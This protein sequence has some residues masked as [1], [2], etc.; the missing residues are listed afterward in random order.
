MAFR[1]NR[2][3]F[4]FL[5]VASSRY[6]NK[7]KIDSDS[8]DLV[9]VHPDTGDALT[10][11][12][13]IGEKASDA[14]TLD[15]I[16]STGFVKTTNN[17]SLNGDTRNTRGVTRLYRREDNSDYSL[18]HYWTGSYWYLKGYSG[19]T[20][21]AGVQVAYADYAA[22]SNL[23]DGVNSTSFLRSDT[24]DTASAR[25]DFTADESIRLKG[26]R[27]QFTNEYM[28][29]YNKVGI[30]HPN[31]WGEGEGDTPN[32]GLSTYGGLNIAYGNSAGSVFNGGVDVNGDFTVKNSRILITNP[33]GTGGGNF[34]PT[35]LAYTAR[36]QTYGRAQLLLA[37][38]YSDITIGSS[39]ANDNHGSTLTFAT[40]N[41]A[42]GADYK[43]FVIGQGN[44]GARAG[45]LDF[46]YDP[47]NE[48][49]NPHN[50]INSSDVVFT[51]DADNNRI[52]VNSMS[53]SHGL[54]VNGNAHISSTL[55]VDGRVYADNG[56][57]VRGDW[58][59]V[60]GNTGIYFESHAG[61]WF[62]QDSSWVRVYNNKGIYTAGN[63]EV[64]GTSRADNGFKVGANTVIDSN[65]NIT[66][67]T[68]VVI[69]AYALRHNTANNRLEFVLV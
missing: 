51:I 33:S 39:Q 41:P 52:G 43:K 3:I 24:A 8:G 15:G 68:E 59:R 27:G 4:Q 45:F 5:D 58:V 25:I 37:S 56:L 53:P 9:E 32:Y 44:W 50:Y 23:L 67:A 36:E 60:N 30:G 61:G 1:I 69:G 29:L 62:M 26:I 16:N 10:G 35:T 55:E 7:F 21:H 22:N 49:K 13:K 31:G 57:H 54:D 20:Y 12:L 6:I 14:D 18:Q 17:S 2:G 65:R 11:Y 47:G 63:I 42:N 38:G 19:D 64:G 28:H 34:D 48:S 66:A 46:G 40:V